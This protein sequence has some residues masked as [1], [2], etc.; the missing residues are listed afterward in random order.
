MQI[1]RLHKRPLDRQSKAILDLLT[2]ELADPASLRAGLHG[3]VT[4]SGSVAH[5]IGSAD[6]GG[7]T[8]RVERL[9][10]DRYLVTRYVELDT[11][12]EDPEL[13]DRVAAPEVELVRQGGD[14]FAVAVRRGAY[15]GAEPDALE[16][17]SAALRLVAREQSLPTARGWLS[18]LASFIPR[19]APR[20]WRTGDGR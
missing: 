14:W 3:P 19:Q 5:E 11:R 20:L 12:S 1:A 8:V 13:N 7:P 10:A 2:A 18:W 15:A 4:R 16:L 17:V 6:D 9:S